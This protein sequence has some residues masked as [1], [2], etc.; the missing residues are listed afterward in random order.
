MSGS[1]REKLAQDIFAADIYHMTVA[2][3]T[4][5]PQKNEYKQPMVIVG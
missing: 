4:G 5:M 2:Q 3:K 1:D